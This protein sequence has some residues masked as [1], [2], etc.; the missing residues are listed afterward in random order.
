[1]ELDPVKPSHASVSL[2]KWLNPTE[3]NKQTSQLLQIK[4]EKP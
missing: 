3:T 4:L 1:M 2:G